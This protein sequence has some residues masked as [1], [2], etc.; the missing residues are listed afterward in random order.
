MTDTYYAK[1]SGKVNIPE[2]LVIGDGYKIVMDGEVVRDS[3]QNNEHNGDFD[4]VYT[5]KPVHATIEDKFGT[6]NKA[7]DARSKS[8]ILRRA[9]WKC[10]ETDADSTDSEEAYERTMNYIL[11][12]LGR[13]YEDAKKL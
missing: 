12:H 8:T 4:V 1:I 13:I 3:R 7:K 10:W 2:P 11:V 9:I 5:V 6:I